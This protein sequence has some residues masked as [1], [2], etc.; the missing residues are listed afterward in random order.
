LGMSYT[1]IK[2]LTLGAVVRNVLDVK[3]P[4]T[5]QGATFQQGYDP[6]FTDPLGRAVTVKASYKF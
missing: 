6:R 5:N 1:G 3:P 4:F 2:N